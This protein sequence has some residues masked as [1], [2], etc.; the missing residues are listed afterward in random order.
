MVTIK[1]THKKILITSALPY[2]NNVPHLGNLIGC[3]LS[4]DVYARFQRSCKRDVLYIC[5]TDEH[6]TTTEAKAREEGT[7]PQEICDKY[8]KI[9]KEIYDWF[10]ISFD[11]FGRTS[12]QNHVERTQELF[13]LLDE[14]GFI[15]E[16]TEQQLYSEQSK[17]FLSDRY[18]EGTCPHCGYEKARGDQCDNCGKLLNP[19]D[20]INPVSTIDGAKPVVKETTHLYLN[21][22][23]LQEEL[24]HWA[25]PQAELGSWTPNAWTTTKGWFKE[26]LKERAIT[27]DLSWGVRVPKEGFE[28]KVFYVWFDAPIGY[29]SITEQ[30]LGDAW[31]EWWRQPENTLLYQFMAKDNIPFHTILF[32][33][34]LIGSQEQHTLLHHINSTEYLNYEDTKFS[35]S[36]GTGIFGDDAKNTGIPSDVWRYYLLINRPESADTTFHWEDFQEKLNNELVANIGNLVNRVITFVNKHNNSQIIKSDLPEEKLVFWERVQQKE[37]LITILLEEVKLKEALKE[38]MRLSRMGNQFFQ[39]QTPWKTIKEDPEDAQE[40]LFILA[41]LVKDLS[42]LIEPYMPQTAKSI[43]EQLK[44]NESSWHDLGQLSVHG[45]INEA[46]LLFE[47]LDDISELKERFS[48]QEGAEVLDLRVATIESVEKHPKADKLYIEHL[49]LGPLGKKTI[50]SGLVPY[51]KEE[52]LVG[53][54]IILVNNLAPAK[55]RGV[56]SQG[57]LLAAEH[58]GEV[59]VLEAIGEPG[60]QVFLK[61]V[62]HKKK[63]EPITID[64]FFSLEPEIKEGKAGIAGHTLTTKE[65]VKT[66]FMNAKLS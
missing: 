58:D 62:R 59:K 32:P 29:I 30:L 28:N 18:V 66:P 60:E 51:Y 40:S 34:T 15:T 5:G 10:N 56:E 14:N 8:Y 64:F 19:L 53:K 1:S 11:I 54:K 21:L 2:V 63:K 38:I 17:T 39:E 41:N 47:K 36:N 16:K 13:K 42:I 7:T 4:A 26:G 22:A 9:H 50:V 23:K 33:A 37:A 25:G 27:R 57:M 43:Q 35:K 48:G 6:G 46:Q 3:V 55:L 44:L 61:G 65:Q 12:T 31:K 45:D 49:D 52:E 24:E 20:L